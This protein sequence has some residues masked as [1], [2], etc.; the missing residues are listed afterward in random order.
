MRRRGPKRAGAV[1]TD[2]DVHLF[3]EGTHDRAYLKLGSHPA[4]RGG[5]DGTAF[6]VWA[7]G[8][9]RVSVVGEFNR[10]TPGRHPLRLPLRGPL[11]ICARKALTER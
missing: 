2:E 8:A 11:A 10:W 3:N 9:A 7:P 1:L 5:E 4:T 6:A